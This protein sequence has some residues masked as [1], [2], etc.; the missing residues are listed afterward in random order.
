[1][2]MFPI[3][4]MRGP[5]APMRGPSR[6]PTPGQMSPMLNPRFGGRVMGSFKKGGTVKRTGNYRL[7]RGEK[8][9]PL[10]RLRHAR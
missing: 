1:M 4:P 2:P 9:V 7:H 10:S 6:V 5:T 3:R 8:V